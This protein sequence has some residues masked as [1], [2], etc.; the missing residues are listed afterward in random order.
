M[1]IPKTEYP[2]PQFVRDGWRCLNGE[3]SFEFD[4]GNSGEERGYFSPTTVFSRKILVPFAPESSLSGINNK[5]FC[6]SVWYSRN[7]E[8]SEEQLNGRVILHFEAVDY[9]CT[10]AVNGTI[11]GSHKGGYTPFSFDITGCLKAGNNTITVRARDD[12]RSGL[13]PVG[14][15]SRTFYSQVCDY[16]RTTGI[17]QTVWLE[18]VPREYLLSVQVNPDVNSSCAFFKSKVMG[19]GTG[20]TCNTVISYKGQE[21]ARKEVPLCNSSVEYGIPIR[22]IH[23]W[24]V[25][26]PELY[27]VVYELKRR[28]VVLDRVGSYFGFR[29]IEWENGH[30]VRLN[31]R[32]VYQRLV[33]DQGFYPDGIYTAPSDEALKKD[34]ELALSLGFNG[35]RLH[36]KVFEERYLYWADQ[37]GFLTWGEYGNWGL[38]IS[39]SGGLAVFLPEWMEAVKR[40]INHPCIIGWCP[41]NETLD[42]SGKR[43]DDRVLSVTYQVTKAMDSTRP[44][45][46]TSGYFHVVTDI[47]DVHDY[48]QA[49]PVFQERY[50]AITAD[51][52]Y[53]PYSKRQSYAGQ[54]YFVSEYGGA[55]WNSRKDGDSWGYGDTPQSE[56][57]WE[58]RYVG[59]TSALMDNPN[60]CAF[61]YTQ[62]YDVEQEKNGLFTYERSPKF[63]PSV[64]DAVRKTNAQKAAIEREE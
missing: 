47:Y 3:W 2:R 6:L 13:Q 27:D 14:K 35:A 57:E 4:Y 17:W 42:P 22:D 7:V 24:D 12:T 11:A 51:A 36:Q 45:I 23:L 52:V 60:I 37:L 40:D 21:V 53:D 10:A 31:G 8:I 44:V 63:S 64:Y 38:D 34:I 55:W 58:D 1:E 9:E 18:F 30:S 5:D 48:E 41:F 25:A 39:Q 59:L 29:C 26:K 20:L 33:L 54:P 16:T 49:V 19:G 32:P 56:K 62:L 28:D 61:C 46:D 15:Q 43:Q 50:A